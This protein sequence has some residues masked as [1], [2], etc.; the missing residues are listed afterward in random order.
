MLTLCYD[1]SEFCGWQAQHSCVSVQQTLKEAVIKYT[2]YEDIDI[3]GSGRTDSGVHAKAQVAHIEVSADC[4]IPAKAFKPALNSVLP[5]SVRILDSSDVLNSF[6]ARYSTLSREYRYF[7]VKAPPHYSFLDKYFCICDCFPDLTL[8]NSYAN[9]ILGTHNFTS[10]TGSGDSSKSKVRDVYESS[11]YFDK[12]VYGYPL[13]CY[14]ITANAFLYRM[15][16]S[17]CGTMFDLGLSSADCSVFKDI[18]SSQDRSKA[19]KTA[20]SGGLYLWNICYDED[21]FKELQEV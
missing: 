20:Y 7:W 19:G 18:L 17:L 21:L 9:V 12:T 4:K 8:L 1:G 5:Y 16:R 13:L 15:I 3:V 6:H 14:K 11:F 2:G 10:F